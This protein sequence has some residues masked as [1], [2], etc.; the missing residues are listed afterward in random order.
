[1]EKLFFLVLTLLLTTFSTAQET[2]QANNPDYGYSESD[3][4]FVGGKDLNTGSGIEKAYLDQLTGPQGEPVSYKKTGTCC[5]F[6]TENFGMG[7]LDIYQVY[8]KGLNKPVFLYLN[9]YEAGDGKLK[10]PQ[11]FLWKSSL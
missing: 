4:I 3:P 7:V 5:E 6:E 9:I 1:M 10:Y 8:H 11:G 2:V